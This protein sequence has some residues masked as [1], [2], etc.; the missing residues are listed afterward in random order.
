MQVSEQ[1][2]ALYSLGRDP[3]RGA[4]R[5]AHH[6]RDAV[7]TAAARG[8]RQRRRALRRHDRRPDH[9]GPGPRV[10]PLRRAAVLAQ[11][12]PVLLADEGPRV[13]LHHPAH[14]RATWAC[15]TRGGAE[16]VGRATTASVVFMIIAVLVL[17]RDV[18]APVPQ[19]A[20]D[21]RVPRRPQG[22]RRAR[23]GGREPDRRDGRDARHR[24]PLGHR[25]ERAAQDDHRP[26]RARPGRRAHRRASPWSHAVA[27]G[28]AGDPAQGRATS[29]ST[30]RSSTR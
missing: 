30:P 7:V 25:Q 16:G 10:V 29:S 26:H 14:L 9:R 20:A 3:V 8:H 11:L 19:L 17:G 28:A 13:R 24:R 12:G 27:R 2:D 23:A 5:A 4:G 22:L 1:I 6:R 21:D 18:P 15:S